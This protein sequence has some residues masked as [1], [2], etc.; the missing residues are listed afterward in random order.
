M[1][2]QRGML[3][4]ALSVIALS[5]LISAAQDPQ[6]SVEPVVLSDTHGYDFGPYLHEMT[7]QVMMTWHYVLP[8]A[9]RQ[10]QKG[11]VVEWVLS[12]I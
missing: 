12:F 7:Q 8:E 10:G 9:A 3:V 11:R 1:K 2:V 5:R 4:I 6:V